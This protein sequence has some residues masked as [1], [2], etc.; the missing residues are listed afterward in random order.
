MPAGGVGALLASAAM[1]LAA[2][3]SGV[4]GRA[5]GLSVAMGRRGILTAN[6][7]ER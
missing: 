4:A 2:R 1:P 7:A 6:G 5:S 3:A